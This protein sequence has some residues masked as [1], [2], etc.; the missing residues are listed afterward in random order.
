[1]GLPKFR[2][3]IDVC[4]SKDL[5]WKKQLGSYQYKLL[6]GAEYIYQ[7]THSLAPMLQITQHHNWNDFLFI[8]QAHYSLLG[9]NIFFNRSLKYKFFHD[10]I[11]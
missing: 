7:Y 3:E 2:I 11:A 9:G 4:L 6:G 10:Y 1:M 5:Q 8:F